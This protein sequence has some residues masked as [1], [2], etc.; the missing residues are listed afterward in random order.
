MILPAKL[1]ANTISRQHFSE[2]DNI[3]SDDMLW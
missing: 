1:D 2:E 3:S